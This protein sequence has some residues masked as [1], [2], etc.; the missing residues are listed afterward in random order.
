MK[1]LLYVLVFLMIFLISSCEKGPRQAII[2]TEF[3]NIKVELMDSTPFHRDNFVNLV[4]Q[5]FYNDLLFHRIV[6]DFMIQGGDPDSKNALQNKRLGMGGPGYRINAEIGAL[7]YRGVLAAARQGG[8]SNP[9]MKSSGSQFYL[10]NGKKKL[11]QKDI[12]NAEKYNKMEYT[13]EQIDKYLEGGGYPILDTKYTVFGK[14]IEG[15]EVLDKISSVE[16]GKFSRP[17]K[18]I[19]MKVRMIN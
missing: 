15:M 8:P 5:G 17:K 13:Q 11:T 9:E 1:Q 18:D 6:E 16:I 12:S 14:V 3:G 19:K 10:V 4:D 2:E 7:H